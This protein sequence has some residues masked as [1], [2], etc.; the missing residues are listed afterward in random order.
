MEKVAKLDPLGFNP[1]L[2]VLQNIMKSEKAHLDLL[3]TNLEKVKNILDENQL[4]SFESLFTL[5]EQATEAS[6]K[7][8]NTL[9]V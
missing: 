2:M 1:I 8:L 6:I 4:K 3:S 5:I 9:H 7:L